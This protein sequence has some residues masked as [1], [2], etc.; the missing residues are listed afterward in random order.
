MW[1][2][3]CPYS[4]DWTKNPILK[5]TN[6]SSPEGGRDTRAHLRRFRPLTPLAFPPVTGRGEG[7]W[8]PASLTA[9]PPLGRLGG[10]L[11][12]G[13]Q[14]RNSAVWG[15]Q[16][17]RRLRGWG[18]WSPWAPIHSPRQAQRGRDK[19]GTGRDR[20]SSDETVSKGKQK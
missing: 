3:S 9:R 2:V 4:S 17:G 6:S 8:S 13:G 5:K 18:L 1:S 7:A 10:L 16:G 14:E 12:A 19:G 11:G 20:G 15:V